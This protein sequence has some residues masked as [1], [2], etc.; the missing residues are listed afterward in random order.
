MPSPRKR[1]KRPRRSTR[2]T[3]HIAS[4]LNGSHLLYS[5]LLPSGTSRPRSVATMSTFSGV[6]APSTYVCSATQLPKNARDHSASKKRCRIFHVQKKPWQRSHRTAKYSKHICIAK[7]A[8]LFLG[9][10]SWFN[11]CNQPLQNKTK[12]SRTGES[13]SGNQ[14]P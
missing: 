13:C 3:A 10:T 9:E 6:T 7:R 8:V 1:P 12:T 4:V 5:D 11:S 14:V 2:F